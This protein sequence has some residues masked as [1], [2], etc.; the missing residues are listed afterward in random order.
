[1]QNPPLLARFTNRLTSVFWIWDAPRMRIT[2]GSPWDPTGD[3]LTG[4]VHGV[5]VLVIR[6]KSKLKPQRA[7]PI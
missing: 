6:L 5:V 3:R 7:M 2:A 1:M 4:R